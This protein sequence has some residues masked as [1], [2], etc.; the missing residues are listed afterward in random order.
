MDKQNIWLISISA[1]IFVVIA[2]PVNVVLVHDFKSCKFNLI[3]TSFITHAIK[4]INGTFTYYIGP[5]ITCDVFVAADAVTTGS[6]VEIHKSQANRC[7]LSN[8]KDECYGSLLLFN[9]LFTT[10]GL[11]IIVVSMIVVVDK[12]EKKCP[13]RCCLDD[14]NIN[15]LNS[16]V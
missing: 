12:L 16:S 9:A 8:E 1:V 5:N 6:D 7:G 4:S 15:L 14:E 11:L 10:V 3:D 13:N 2:I